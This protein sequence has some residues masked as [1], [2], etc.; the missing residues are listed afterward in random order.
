M[1]NL[2]GTSFILILKGEYCLI[3]LYRKIQNE[4]FVG[5]SGPDRGKQNGRENNEGFQ[6]RKVQVRK[7]YKRNIKRHTT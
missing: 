5:P 1:S 4:I 2:K 3:Q 6:L 7:N